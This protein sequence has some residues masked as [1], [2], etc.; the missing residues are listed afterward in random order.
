[1][2]MVTFGDL[3]SLLLCFFVLLLSFSTMDP[4]MF[5]EVSGSLERAFGV[6]KQEITFD[7]P[8]GIDIVSREFNPVFSV[9]VVMEKI[10]SAIKLEL[11][12]GEV[13]VE[14]LTDR[15]ILRMNDEITFAPGSD[16]LTPKAEKILDKIRTIVETVPGKII[17]EGYTDDSPVAGKFPSNW[18]LS[19]ARASSVV[20]FMLQKHSILPKRMAATGYGASRPRVPNDTPEHRAANRRVDIVFMQP[21]KPDEVEVK[22]LDRKGLLEQELLPHA[23]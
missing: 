2:W 12:K 9:D 1:M 23:F 13:E 21:L 5:K 14:A 20:S 17:V 10:K 4:A 22:S 7:I 3:M 8:K 11:I 16:R 6:Q 18:H 15:V 19:S